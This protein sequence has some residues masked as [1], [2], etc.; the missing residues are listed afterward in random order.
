MEVIDK[1]AKEIEYTVK[2]NRDEMLLLL[3]GTY[4]SSDVLDSAGDKLF[5]DLLEAL[6]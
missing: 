1:Q 3:M 4:V 5:D 2:L 6:R